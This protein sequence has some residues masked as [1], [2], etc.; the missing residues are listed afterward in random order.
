MVAQTVRMGVA[1]L[2][3]NERLALEMAEKALE[4]FEGLPDNQLCGGQGLFSLTRTQIPVTLIYAGR[5]NEAEAV[6]ER[7]VENSH[8]YDSGSVGHA[9]ALLALS[10]AWRGE[11]PSK[12]V[13]QCK[14]WELP[15]GLAK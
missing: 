10:T 5:W 2:I 7:F 9:K 15:V 14:R 11:D 3:G 12:W 4:T 6:L 1:R 8:G 13:E